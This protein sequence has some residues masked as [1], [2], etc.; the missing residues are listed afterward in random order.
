[1]SKPDWEEQ[2]DKEFEV[3][4]YLNPND[5]NPDSKNNR[6]FVKAINRHN[7]KVKDFIRSLL[8]RQGEHLEHCPSENGLPCKCGVETARTSPKMEM[9]DEEA[10]FKWYDNLNYTV[11]SE[12]WV[13]IVLQELCER[14]APPKPL[15]EE[16]VAEIIWHKGTP[17]IDRMECS[18]LAKAII[19]QFT[20]PDDGELREVLKPVAEAIRLARPDGYKDKDWNPYAHAESITL[21][22]KECR[23]ILKAEKALGVK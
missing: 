23:A 13:R 19:S 10:V 16:K 17:P 8:A 9:L 21:T 7:E 14:F 6:G 20:A 5:I 12:T 2:F 4:T 3:E 22:I 11:E 15:D 18:I 1:M